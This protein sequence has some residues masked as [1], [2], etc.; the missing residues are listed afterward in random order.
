MAGSAI[1]EGDRQCTRLHGSWLVVALTGPAV[2]AS[3]IFVSSTVPSADAGVFCC[4][5][6]RESPEVSGSAVTEGDR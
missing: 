2:F 3:T 6:S 5:R 1:T 4:S